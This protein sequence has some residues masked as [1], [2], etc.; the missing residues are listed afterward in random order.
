MLEHIIDKA[1][2]VVN[3]PTVTLLQVALG[4]LDHLN[5]GNGFTVQLHSISLADLITLCGLGGKIQLP[6]LVAVLVQEAL[7]FSLSDL[8]QFKVI[9]QQPHSFASVR[10]NVQDIPAHGLPGQC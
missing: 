2:P 9:L 3:I 4:L 8:H 6:D 7:P 5:T 10:Y 1:L